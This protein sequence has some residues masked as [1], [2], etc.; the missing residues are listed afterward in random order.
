MRILKAI[1]LGTLYTAAGLAV[2]LVFLHL[3]TMIYYHE[4]AIHFIQSMDQARIRSAEQYALSGD[5]KFLAAILSNS[6][7]YIIIS[8]VLYIILITNIARQLNKNKEENNAK[9]IKS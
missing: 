4:S 7:Y 9:D 5:N 1:L 8:A 6:G 3:T 2:A